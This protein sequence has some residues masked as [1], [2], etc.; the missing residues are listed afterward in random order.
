MDF[1]H[2]F[3]TISIAP[4]VLLFLSICFLP[5]RLIGI[6]FRVVLSQS[7]SFFLILSQYFS[8]FSLL[9]QETAFPSSM[10]IAFTQNSSKVQA[11][12]SRHSLQ[13]LMSHALKT[14]FGKWLAHRFFTKHTFLS[15]NPAPHDPEI[16]L[17]LQMYCVWI[18]RETSAPIIPNCD[19]VVTDYFIEIFVWPLFHGELVLFAW[20]SKNNMLLIKA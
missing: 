14:R 20:Q 13:I 17:R 1:F 12:I 8:F 15:R 5:L 10:Q 2:L 7:F 16:W 19:Q 6:H 4:S 11:K 3:S 18:V 9:P